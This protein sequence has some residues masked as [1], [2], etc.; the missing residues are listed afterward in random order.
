MRHG[1]H[2]WAAFWQM[3]KPGYDYFESYRY[4]P[5]I[6]VVNKRYEVNYEKT[7]EQQ[8]AGSMKNVAQQ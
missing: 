8:M 5:V 7:A 3:L 1:G 2:R 6:D 4:P